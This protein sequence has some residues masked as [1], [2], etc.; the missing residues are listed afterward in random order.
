MGSTPAALLPTCHAP[1]GTIGTKGID[2]P[3]EAKHSGGEYEPSSTSEPAVGATIAE[4]GSAAVEAAA[5]LEALKRI[6]N[7]KTFCSRVRQTASMH[8]P[9]VTPTELNLQKMLQS[10]LS[11]I[12]RQLE[13][14][15]LEVAVDKLTQTAV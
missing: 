6:Q 10:A 15:E 3:E 12:Y 14:L 13:S 2:S 7:C 1:T 9:P 11:E 8:S 5:C 4:P